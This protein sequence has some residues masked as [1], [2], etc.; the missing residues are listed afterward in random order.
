MAVIVE[1]L[2]FEK[3]FSLALSLTAP[4]IVIAYFSFTWRSY[5]LDDALIYLRYI[6]NFQEG[7]GLVYNPGEKFNGLTSPLFSYIM[8]ATSFLIKD[9]QTATIIISGIFLCVAAVIGGKIFSSNN[10]ESTL[11][12]VAIGSFGYFYTTYGMETPLFLSLI[13]V[14]FYLRKTDSHYFILALALLVTTRNE[15]IFL[16]VPILLDFLIKNK[17]LPNLKITFLSAAVFITP[18]IFN[19][20][21]YGDFLPATGNA[22][23]EQGKSI[24]WGTGFLFLK[25]GSVIKSTFF[26][27]VSAILFTVICTYGISTLIKN[28]TAVISIVFLSLLLSFYTCLN[29]PN[30]HWYYA[31]FFFLMLIFSCRGFWHFSSI[32]LKNC[33]RSDGVFFLVYLII[34]ALFFFSKVAPLKSGGRFE[35]YVNI[36]EWIKQK[37]PKN[38][39]IA[40]VEIGTI[41][42]HANR[43]I[44]DILGLV[45]KFNA[46]YIGKNDVYSWLK[47]YQ[48]DYI[49]RHQPIWSFEE[50]TKFL[51]ASELYSPVKNFN[52]QGYTL[53]KKTQQHLDKDFYTQARSIK[54][55][56][57]KNLT[58]LLNSSNVG[59]PYLLLESTSLFAHAPSSLVLFLEKPTKSIKVSYGIKP[60]ATKKHHGVCFEIIVEKNKEQKFQRCINEDSG[61][62]EIY[63]QDRVD[64]SANEGEKLIFNI[65]CK[66]SCDNAQSYWDL[67][68]VE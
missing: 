52:V 47:H 36:G 49:L 29:I 1:K 23:I 32:Q 19:Y 60:E 9:L 43:H 16:A 2:S 41:G 45:N 44:I 58:S 30:Y 53:L 51:E 63:F 4:I 21:Y 12:G 56:N 68:L 55:E 18:F 7:Y 57:Q 17:R 10:W 13:A 38:A 5:Q 28:R 66:N 48:P 40:V 20:F 31:P 37:T 64:I 61:E 26:S 42:W 3:Y 65:K 33:F 25:V 6:K 35:P 59:S 50:S 46:N 39:S 24:Y 62:N 15:G 34:S 67:I 8:V 54:I 22:K 14:S 11:T 27:K